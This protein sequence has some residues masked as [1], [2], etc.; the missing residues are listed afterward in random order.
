MRLQQLPVRILIATDAWLPQVNG[1][2]STLKQTTSQ[3]AA[4][5]HD[6]QM[7]TPLDF[8]T[9]A[10][11]GY[12]EIRVAIGVGA[13]VRAKFEAFQPQAVHVAT[14]GPIGF[15]VRAQC[16]ARGLRFTTSYHTQF[17]Q[18]LRKRLP[19]PVSWS[20]AL[21]RWFHS[22][23]ERCMV[24]TPSMH[25]E[26]AG[27]GFRNLVRWQ[28][29][30]DAGL[31]RPY[32]KTF[33][34]LPR[35]IAV[36]VGRLAVEKNIDAFL[37]MPWKG[38]KVVVGDGPDRDRLQD[39]YPQAHFVGYQ[40]GEKL[41]RHIS[42]SDVMVFPSQTDTFGLV[43]LEAMACGVP[44]AAFP[45]T[46]PVDVIEEG[47]TGALD[48][49]LAAAARRALRISPMACRERAERS[50]WASCTREFESHLVHSGL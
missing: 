7:I 49:D 37:G 43:N 4:R 40:Q 50:S 25:K 26:L 13:G 15:G 36:Y 11:P 30:V 9:V 1:V 3:L 17:P 31:F 14:E 23:G 12:K 38:S 46:G 41:A 5:G 45:V 44:V 24:S 20:Y 27:R 10:C 48:W 18:Y 22:A 21:L 32:E 34:D 29:G 47:I 28:R 6:V 8:A 19:M 16:R 39:R 42:A 33:L 35:P 2:V